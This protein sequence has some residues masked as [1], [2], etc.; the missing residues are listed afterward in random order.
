M[1]WAE[2]GAGGALVGLLLLGILAAVPRLRATVWEAATPLLLIVG[3]PVALFAAVVLAEALYGRA[4]RAKE[5]AE[6]E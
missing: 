6:M 1:P 5:E 4:R 3:V 2:L